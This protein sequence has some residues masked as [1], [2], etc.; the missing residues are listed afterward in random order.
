METAGEPA[1]DIVGGVFAGMSRLLADM[2]D[3]FLSRPARTLTLLVSSALSV[4]LLSTGLNRLLVIHDRSEALL[5]SLPI[6]EQLLRFSEGL[7]EVE[8]AEVRA[9]SKPADCRT[10]VPVV[11]KRQGA[12]VNVR[13]WWG[14]PHPLPAWEAALRAGRWFDVLDVRSRKAVALVDSVWAQRQ[15][16]GV[17]DLLSLNRQAL[18]VVGLIDGSVL[19][20]TIVTTASLG[21]DSRAREAWVHVGLTSDRVVRR[22]EG[23]FRDNPFGRIVDQKQQRADIVAERNRQIRAL[24]GL[25]ALVLALVVL[26]QR[27]LF[28]SEVDDRRGEIGLRRSLGARPPQIG[29]LFLLEAVLLSVLPGGVF[30]LLVRNQVALAAACLVTG[31]SVLTA[32]GPAMRAARLDPITCL[33][34]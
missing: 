27:A 22:W 3:G 17:G 2:M 31:C 16:I 5:A 23:I 18:E 24:F 26:V 10:L 33:R 8:F 4:V 32:L 13:E 6:G 30:V 12:A 7:D 21:K 1:V 15:Q 29:G 34:S 19:E 14:D 9:A 20:A 11:A 28:V 25:A